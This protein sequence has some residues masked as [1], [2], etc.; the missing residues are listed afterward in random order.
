MNARRL[1]SALLVTA[2]LAPTLAEAQVADADRATA[3]QLA[4]QGQDALDKRDF[5][6]AADRFTRADALVHAPTLLLGVARAQAGLGKLVSAQEAYA[7]IVREGVP[8]G[9]PPAF[10]KAVADARAELAALEPRIPNLVINVK[11]AKQ[12]RVTVDGAPVPAAAL[13]VNRPVDPGK[14]LIRAEADGFAAAEAAVVVAESRTESVTIELKASALAPPPV[15]NPPPGTPPPLTPA[16]PTKDA[17]KPGGT[18]RILGFTGLGVGGAALIMGGI[19]G[20]LALSKHASLAKACPE[21]GPCFGQDAAIDSYHLMG[22][23]STVGFIAGGVLAGTGVVLL[24]T[25]P[26]S[27]PTKEASIEPVIGLGFVGAKGSF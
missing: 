17:A 8:A 18:Q 15:V 26:K 6:T 27:R 9:A 10:A 11:G 1:A 3:R 12:P 21:T 22:T 7:R 19:T 25:A 5:V 20:G 23:L 2:L 16:A 4:Q 24:V 13:G 14:H